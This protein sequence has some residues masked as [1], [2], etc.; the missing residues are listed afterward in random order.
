LTVNHQHL[1]AFYAVA[2]EHSFSRAA[3]KLNISQPTLSQQIKALETRHSTS[4]FEGRR[5]PLQLTPTGR[6]LLALTQRLF[7]TSDLIGEMLGHRS[8]DELPAVRIA[9]DSPIYAA[10]LAQALLQAK[11]GMG[12][13]VQIDNARDTSARLLD[14]R[15]DVAIISDPQIDPRF[16]Y[17]P[18]F[19]DY[20]KVL[21]PASHRLAG[22]GV[23][24]LSAFAGE[25][26]LM[27]EASSKTRA[28]IESLLRARDIRPGTIVELHSREAIREAVALGM[29]ISLFFS[30]ECPP[31][32]RL[33]A[34]E[35]ECQ[36]DSALLTGY[37]VYRIEQ[38]RSATVRLVLSAATTLEALSPIPLELL[39]G[40]R[41]DALR[42][43]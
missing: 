27:R 1:R 36:P 21:L 16:A 35:P 24:P 19:V 40:K 25:C 14:A 30:A 3:R 18:L 12:V 6:E 4:L 43:G 26:L 15:A 38:R 11:P 41:G 9:S 5:P 7:A 28:A 2:I 37:V 22:A 34:L 10:R 23:Y 29:G 20:L 31:D 17:Q 33:V 32:P 13:E 8:V 42:A 39:P